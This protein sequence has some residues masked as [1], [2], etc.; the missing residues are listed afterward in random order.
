MD[1]KDLIASWGPM[2]RMAG[3]KSPLVRL[4]AAKR[5]A[6]KLVGD[7]HNAIRTDALRVLPHGSTCSISATRYGVMLQISV[8]E[9]EGENALKAIRK[10]FGTAP[11]DGIQP[12]P[13]PGRASYNLNY[14]R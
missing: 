9:A 12:M 4:N 3:K 13:K 10:L 2:T 5:E 8:P 1:Q 11:V 6:A 14:T 7:A